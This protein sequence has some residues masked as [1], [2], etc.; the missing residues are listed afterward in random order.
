[1]SINFHIF[2]HLITPTSIFILTTLFLLLHYSVHHSDQDIRGIPH[3]QD[4]VLEV[5]REHIV[6]PLTPVSYIKHSI[7][8]FY[9][10]KSLNLGFV[11][12][13]SKEGCL[14]DSRGD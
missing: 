10:E 12:N 6:P 8:N 4:Y 2:L 9:N 3:G 14:R 13:V 1:M 5:G 11:L 7:S